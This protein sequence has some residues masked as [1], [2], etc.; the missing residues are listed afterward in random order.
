MTLGVFQIL[1]VLLIVV[2]L[3]WR[4]RAGETVGD[5]G[6]G[7]RSFR[8]GLG[9]DDRGSAHRRGG[10][11]S[12]GGGRCRGRQDRRL[13]EVSDRRNVRYRAHRIAAY[14]GRG[15]HRHRPERPSARL[16]HGR[17]LDRSDAQALQPFPHRTRRDDPRGR[18]AGA[19]AEV[20][21]AERE[22]H[23][24]APERRRRARAG[25]RLSSG[26]DPEPP[27]PPASAEGRAISVDNPDEYRD[28][29]AADATKPQA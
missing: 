2:V 1:V 27:A 23:A 25:R 14:R 11:R 21:G 26:A 24:R 12:A 5:V 28:M 18:D 4:V 15:G 17:P 6:K 20:E 29:P 16:A 19:R 22:D 13:T 3:F 7:I 8:K 10:S 9:G